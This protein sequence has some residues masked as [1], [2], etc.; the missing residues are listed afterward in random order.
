MSEAVQTELLDID[1]L[2]FDPNNARSHN[3]KNLDAI[4]TSLEEVGA[5]RSILVD[6]NGQIIAGNGTIEMAKELGMDIKVVKGDRNTIVVVQRDDLTEA[7]KTRAGLWD[8]RAAELATWDKKAVGRIAEASPEQSLLEGIF[9]DKELDKLL[10]A[11]TNALN[12]AEGGTD[13]D[14]EIDGEQSSI[15]KSDVKMVQLFYSEDIQPIFMQRI[16]DLK[17][18]LQIETA[19]VTDIVWEIIERAHSNWCAESSEGKGAA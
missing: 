17:A 5:G 12:L 11:Q 2:T 19:T 7:E 8:N 10:Y 13:E 3:K 6:K 9:T 18:A 14:V 4:K 16:R 15:R 1:D